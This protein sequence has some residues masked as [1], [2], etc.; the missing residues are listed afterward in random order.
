[1]QI[2]N[3]FRRWGP[4][5]A[6]ALTIWILSTEAFSAAQTGRVIVP[7]LHWIFPWMSPRTLLLGHK[8]IR[9]LA[10]VCV[11]FVFGL[12]LLRAVRGEHEEW[13]WRWGVM[14]IALAA[15]YAVLDELHQSFVPLR[16][17]SARDVML[18]AFGAFAAQVVLWSRTRLR[19]RGCR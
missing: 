1:M 7:L 12:L 6:G 16:H 18:D 9:K 5:F 14:A 3:W 8:A 11:Y 15:G 10:H 4:V 2:R 13:K 19:E 17:P